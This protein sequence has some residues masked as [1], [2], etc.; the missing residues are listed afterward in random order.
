MLAA[1]GKSGGLSYL[2]GCDGRE[3]KASPVPLFWP[4]LTLGLNLKQHRGLGG[5]SATSGVLGFMVSHTYD[6]T[7][8]RAFMNLG[9]WKLRMLQQY[10]QG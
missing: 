3:S 10:A 5:V 1:T 8:I 4:G 6:W 7:G 2:A 9:S